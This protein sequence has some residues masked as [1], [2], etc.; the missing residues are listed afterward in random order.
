MKLLVDFGATRIKAVVVNEGVVIDKEEVISPSARHWE[1]KPDH[2]QFNANEFRHAWESVVDPLIQRQKIYEIR[3]CTEMHGVIHNGTFYSWKDARKNSAEFDG[4]RFKEIT[5]MQLRTGIPWITLQSIELNGNITVQTIVDYCIGGNKIHLTQAHSIGLVDKETGDWS[6]DLIKPITP[7]LQLPIIITDTKQPIGQYND[8]PVFGG[9]GD[10]QSALLGAGLGKCMDG[11]INLGTGSQVAL[12]K[13]EEKVGE[14]RPLVNGK[15]TVVTH[16]PSGRA[17]NIIANFVDS[18]KPDTF[19][20]IWN[21]LTVD[22]VL[23]SR[24]GVVDLNMFPSA[25]RY[26]GINTGFVMMREDYTDVRAII[27]STA[28]SWIGQYESALLYMDHHEYS[29]EIAVSGGL[30]KANWVVPTFQQLILNRNFH[31]VNT[32]TGEET[33]DGLLKI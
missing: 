9:I 30:A 25:W 10:L 4:T 15:A 29:K 33:L 13:A 12:I 14:Y 18:I 3:V 32:V 11:V 23:A 7:H 31:R 1:C 24:T 8:I 22:E 20:E 19:W 2:F 26:R 21:S 28:H 27:A 6:E 17:L 5:G 16:I